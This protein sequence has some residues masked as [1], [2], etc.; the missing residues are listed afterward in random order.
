[1]IVASTQ[2]FKADTTQLRTNKR[3][4]RRKVSGNLLI[5]SET[6]NKATRNVTEIWDLRYSV[7]EACYKLQTKAPLYSRSAKNSTTSQRTLTI[8]IKRL[9]YLCYRVTV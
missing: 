3:R 6:G 4:E 1:M 2:N 8:S 7:M 5:G 9:L